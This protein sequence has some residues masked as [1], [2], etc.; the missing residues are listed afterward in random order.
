M[1]NYNVITLSCSF[2]ALLGHMS[3]FHCLHLQFYLSSLFVVARLSTTPLNYSYKHRCYD[4]HWNA[5][6]SRHGCI[7][8]KLSLIS[9]SLV[10]SILLPVQSQSQ[11]YLNQASTE[12]YSSCALMQ[13]HFI[14]CS[15]RLCT[16]CDNSRLSYYCFLFGTRFLLLTSLLEDD[17]LC[18]RFLL[19][20]DTSVLG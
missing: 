4:V 18:L 3:P 5:L 9:F 17:L 15:S 7:K 14:C 16:V 6:F 13:H 19:C 1:L 8:D 12:L 10:L 11:S 20:C 2:I